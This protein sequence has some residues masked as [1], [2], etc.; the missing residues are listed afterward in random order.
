[1]D[2]CGS[3]YL[4]T[5][6]IFVQVELAGDEV[7][8]AG[9]LE[10]DDFKN[11]GSLSVV[12]LLAVVRVPQEDELRHIFVGTSSIAVSSE[13]VWLRIRVAQEVAASKK[14]GLSEVFWSENLSDAHYSLRSY[15]EQR[16]MEFLERVDFSESERSYAPALHEF[17]ATALG[18]DFAEHSVDTLVNVRSIG[19]SLVN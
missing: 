13:G 12:P 7:L 8:T 14:T 4:E 5:I 10:G 19:Y 6:R 2:I 3:N 9:T 1:M 15:M 18:K 16:G 11:D 17:I